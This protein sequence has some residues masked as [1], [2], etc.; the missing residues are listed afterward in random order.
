MPDGFG[1]LN[2]VAVVREDCRPRVSE[3]DL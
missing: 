1:N 3:D 2:S